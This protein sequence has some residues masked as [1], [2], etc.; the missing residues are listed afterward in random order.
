MAWG[1]SIS[2]WQNLG[3]TYLYLTAVASP[4]AWGATMVIVGLL[5]LLGL[6]YGS[7]TLYRVGLAL[8]FGMWGAIA[9]NFL[10]AGNA[11]TAVAVYG[12]LCFDAMMVFIGIRRGDYRQ[13]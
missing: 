9:L 10:K 4:S 6:Y 1:V 11:S 2:G 3:S 5:M 12:Y 7:L 8:S 13:P